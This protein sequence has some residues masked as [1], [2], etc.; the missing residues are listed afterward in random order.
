[1]TSQAPTPPR[2]PDLLDGDA[3]NVQR[4]QE[5][6]ATG[7]SPSGSPRP[8]SDLS[9]RRSK[10]DSLS[11]LFPSSL[12]RSSSPSFG[13]P[14]ISR[15]TDSTPS[16]S[17]TP[18]LDSTSTYRNLIFQGFAP[19]IA[20]LPSNDVEELLAGKGFAEGLLQLL[21]PYGAKI[22]GRVTIRD[23]NG[24]SK[25]WEDFAVR[26]V[27]I[28]DGLEP[29]R[30]ERKSTESRPQTVNGYIDHYFPAS[31][32]RLR[33]GGDMRLI[34]DV[35]EKHL[36]FAES[37]PTPDEQDYFTHDT[38]H[39]GFSESPFHVLYLQKLLSG[40]P[41]SPHET[42]SHPVACIIA[43]SS[44]NADPVEELRNLHTASSTGDQRLPQWVYPDY[45]RYYV[46]VHDEDHDDI[47][48]STAVFDNM[49]RHFGLHCY[50][51]RLRSSQC[52]PTD[53]G[54]VRLPRDGWI[55]AAEELAELE[56]EQVGEERTTWLFE[57]DSDAT[58]GFVREM[59]T[60][61]VIPTMERSCSTWNDQVASRR[62]GISGRFISLSKK[63]TFGSKS[64]TGNTSSGSNYDSVQG[65]YRPDTPEAIIR[66]LADYCFML[67]DFKLAQST[68]DI[69]RADF[70][71]DK[72]WKYY[73]GANEM[74]VLTSLMV[75]PSLPTKSKTD[76][77][78]QML[79]AASYSYM[80]RCHT[81]FYA[82]RTLVIAAELFSL[83]AASHAD[84]A[85][86]WACRISELELVGPIGQVLIAE[87]V[88]AF[89]ALKRG[90][91]S[92]H[93]GG[94]RRKAGMWH[95]LAAE[96]WLKME[97]N[98]QAERCLTEA[99][100]MYRVNPQD[101]SGLAFEDMR[102]HLMGLKDAVAAEQGTM[103]AFE[104]IQMS[105]GTLDPLGGATGPLEEMPAEKLDIRSHRRSLIGM[106]TSPTDGTEQR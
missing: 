86:R 55:S 44:R 69:L 5:Q 67:R 34:E 100:R 93:W 106:S 73:A 95:V 85:A 79:E 58:R 26:F 98:R 36:S 70:S 77:M 17:Q 78:E 41:L 76:T 39:T 28:R 43:A 38:T 20:V 88:A 37:N 7:I 1:M 11:T 53:D 46:L 90:S 18:V 31:A 68:Y 15:L 92:R 62:R 91:G 13:L 6:K 33:T 99:F 87:R 32:A 71:N 57:S 97:K 8:F 35:V 84:D 51:L 49:K 3:L 94:R 63:W 47:Q 72:A 12:K 54:S 102:N 82:L 29:P 89:Y 103:E 75:L 40:L 59:V 50:L 48:R 64:S 45:L 25:T 52:V 4:T 104:G 27:K 83:R 19:H 24:A 9:F 66:K 42:F 60:Q 65:F 74:T 23:S 2:T 96:A 61:S 105:M 21:R 16:G 30:G 101:P 22:Q 80:T 56:K 14:Q 81:P 10:N